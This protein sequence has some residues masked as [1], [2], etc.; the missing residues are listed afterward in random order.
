MLRGFCICVI[1]TAQ[2]IA[3]TLHSC[4]ALLY[5]CYAGRHHVAYTLHC[6]MIVSFGRPFLLHAIACLLQVL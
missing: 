1:A 5:G 3:V 6:T 2:R 4:F